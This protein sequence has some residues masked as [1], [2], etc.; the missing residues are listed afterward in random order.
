MADSPIIDPACEFGSALSDGDVKSILQSLPAFILANGVSCSNQQTQDLNNENL[1]NF[2]TGPIAL[3]TK[4]L[5]GLHDNQEFAR[6]IWDNFLCGFVQEL[7]FVQAIQGPTA[8][9]TLPS[10]EPTAR[11]TVI[12]SWGCLLYTSPSPRD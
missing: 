4:A 5:A 2:L 9:I 7:F 10:P 12:G 1:G 11:Y 6:C 3:L 8:T